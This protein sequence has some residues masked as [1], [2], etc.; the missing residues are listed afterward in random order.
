MEKKRCAF[1]NYEKKEII[2]RGYNYCPPQYIPMIGKIK[3]D[4]V[5]IIAWLKRGCYGE[6]EGMTILN[7]GCIPIPNWVKKLNGKLFI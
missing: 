7:E 2:T 1:Y 6:R 3:T 4:G 5:K